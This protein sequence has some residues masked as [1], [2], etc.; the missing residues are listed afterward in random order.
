MRTERRFWFL[1]AVVLGCS[2]REAQARIDGREFAEWMVFY[3]IE[4]FGPYRGDLQ[5]AV[6]A[7]NVREA[8]TPREND[9]WRFEE[10]MPLLDDNRRKQT[11]EQV[12]SGWLSFVEAH[13]AFHGR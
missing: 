4:P 5:A 10:F 3:R 8:I 13:N 1:L 2:V 9:P 12:L 11:P 6:V 7:A